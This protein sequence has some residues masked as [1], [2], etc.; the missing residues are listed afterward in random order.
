MIF[1]R[2]VSQV[3]PF[4]IFLCWLLPTLFEVNAVTAKWTCRGK[5]FYYCSV[6]AL[7]M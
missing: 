4:R 3:I 7:H 5:L 1:A 6:V 2:V